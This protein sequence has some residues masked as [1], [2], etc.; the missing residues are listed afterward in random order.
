MSDALPGPAQPSPPP[1]GPPSP[2]PA[3][4]PAAAAKP[5]QGKPT[6]WMHTKE[7]GAVW[8]IRFVVM[9]C[10]VFGRSAGRAFLYFLAFYYVAFSS[11]VRRASRLYF[12]KLEPGAPC[13]FWKVYRHV[14]TF[15]RVTLDRLFFARGRH[16]LFKAE[17]HGEEHLKALAEKKQGALFIMAHLGSFE[18]ARTFSEDKSYRINVLGYFRNARML[19]SALEKLNPEINM[20]LIDL[21]PDSIDFI[22]TVKER[23]KAGEIVSTMGDRVG[24]DGKHALASFLGTPAPFPTGPFLLAG[25]LNCPVYLAFG[26]YSEPNRYDLYCEPFA[27]RI[28]LPRQDRDRF[29]AEQVQ[30]YAARLEHYCRSSPMNWFNFYDFWELPK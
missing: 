20:R 29:L 19:N 27:E 8:G 10:T 24:A 1:Q 6:A 16:D 26:L 21:T 5:H 25:M 9:L 2:Q 15:A 14:L 30:K 28:K 12:E 4:G 18:A 23:A 13:G 22:F 11:R 7:A 17:T 3:A